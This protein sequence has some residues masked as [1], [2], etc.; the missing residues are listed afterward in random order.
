MT[1]HPSQEI[2]NL[3]KGSALVGKHKL[4]TILKSFCF[5]PEKGCA[6]GMLSHPYAP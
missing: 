1:Q 4:I 2:S 5:V 3:F 6:V